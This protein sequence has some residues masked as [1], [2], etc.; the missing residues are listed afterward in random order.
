MKLSLALPGLRFVFALS[1]GVPFIGCTGSL[2]TRGTCL[3]VTGGGIRHGADLSAGIAV[4]PNEA[5]LFCNLIRSYISYLI[6]QHER[7]STS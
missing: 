4:Q 7:L 5:R 1:G 3:Q 2:P 6:A